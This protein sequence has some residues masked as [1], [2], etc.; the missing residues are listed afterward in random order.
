MEKESQSNAPS[1]ADIHERIARDYECIFRRDGLGDVDRRTCVLRAVLRR[2]DHFTADDIHADL[3]QA[4][5]NGDPEFVVQTL[6]SFVRYGLVWAIR[7][8]DRPI[9]YEHLHVQRH[10]DHVICVRCGRMEE[11]E[12][13]I[14]RWP[15][16]AERATGYHILRAQILLRGL[17][18]DCRA[19]RPEVFALGASGVGEELEVVSLEAEGPD[20]KR[21]LGLGFHRDARV[22]RLSHDSGGVSIVAVEESR[23][24]LSREVMDRVRVRSA[25]GPGRWGHRAA[26]PLTD[27]KVGRSARIVRIC[28]HGPIRHRLLEM[29]IT[30]GVS[31]FVERVAPLGDPMEVTVKGY[32]LAI[33]KEEA[34][35]IMVEPT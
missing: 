18:P 31:V 32:Y 35:Q 14:P 7:T 8:D 23:L 2:E 12:L 6:E 22:Q 15:R 28:G 19:D 27:V 26:I 9:R 29:G 21:L 17:C 13:P 20:L 11:V 5:V 10:H 3:C 34:S 30:R 33:R 24:A 25:A 1:P 4:A 16:R